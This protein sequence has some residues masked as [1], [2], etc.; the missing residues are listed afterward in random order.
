MLEDLT[1]MSDDYMLSSEESLRGENEFF[2]TDRQ[3]K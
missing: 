2:K 3:I 1:I